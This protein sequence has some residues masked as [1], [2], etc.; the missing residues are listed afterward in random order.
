MTKMRFFSLRR[1]VGGRM[2][3]HR[4]RPGRNRVG[5]RSSNH[6]TLADSGIS[7]LHA[8]VEVD[9]NTVFL[10]DLASKNGTFVNGSRIRRCRI[11]PGD[12]VAFGQCRFELVE[13]HRDEA[14]L[15]IELNAVAQNST[16]YTVATT[17]LDSSPE[18]RRSVCDLTMPE[19][20]VPGDS[21]AILELYDQMAPLARSDLP[22][23][24]LGETGVGKE[25]L[26][27]ILH[28][29]S[30]RSDE[31]F[32]A[33]NCAAIPADLLEA[34]LFGVEAGAATGV[35]AR[36]G[37]F[38]RADRGTLFLDEI[39]DMSTGLQAKLLR[40]LQEQEI[41]PVGGQAMV[42]DVRLVAATNAEL[43]RRI[44]SGEFRADLYYRLA[45]CTLEIPPLRRRHGDVAALSDHFL[46]LYAAENGKSI[47][48]MTVRALRQLT[49]YR[50][51]GNVRELEHEIRRLVFMCPVGQ[52]IDESMLSAAIRD[53]ASAPG[54]T[55]DRQ[56]EDESEAPPPDPERFNLAQLE[57]QTIL[58]ALD[59]VGGHRGEA[60]RLLGISRD[61]LRR[62]L[63]RH[64]LWSPAKRR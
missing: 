58:R 25:Y 45:G 34:E 40:A 52:V 21:P 36:L 31:P 5:S 16:S 12:A 17:L 49:E 32:V 9:G 24:L 30:P 27:Q 6:V 33:V 14:E 60:A 54:R 43:G 42:I 13:L 55:G 41:R 38:R 50:W 2:E 63:V 44:E 62:R 53:G 20:Y 51:P 59:T 18:P 28:A 23:L 61:A 47:R 35:S 37:T 4:L 15:A 29:S 39:G 10:E 26:A 56:P 3:T 7:S 19:G 48:G 1:Q 46:R 22:V 11:Q 64:G 8:I 57:K